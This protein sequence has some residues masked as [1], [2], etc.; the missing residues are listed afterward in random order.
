MDYFKFYDIPLT[1]NPDKALVKKKFYELSKTYHPDF[2]INETK[3]KQEE[4]LNLSTLNNEAFQTLSNHDQLL[5]YILEQEGV[6]EEGEKYQLPQSFLMEMMD[7]NEAIM[8]LEFDSNTENLIKV[9]ETVDDFENN[10][11]QELSVLTTDFEQHKG[12]KRNQI[13]KE[14]KDIWYRK[15]YLLRIRESINKFAARL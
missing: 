5:A 7:V 2:Y 14:I 15:K 11:N 8:E 13:L 9:K 6:L 1:F 12:E 4:I 3:E 10:L